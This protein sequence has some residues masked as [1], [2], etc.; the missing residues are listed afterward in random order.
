MN[1]YKKNRVT[2]LFDEKENKELANETA[3]KAD[4]RTYEE[5][6]RILIG[7]SLLSDPQMNQPF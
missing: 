6:D 2:N 7:A 5:A 3:W 1:I 4:E